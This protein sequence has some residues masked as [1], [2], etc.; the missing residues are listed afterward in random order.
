[1]LQKTGPI[2][3]RRPESIPRLHETLPLIN[4]A[5]LCEQEGSGAVAED[6]AN[7]VQEARVNTSLA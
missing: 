1:M 7:N 3:S 5:D 6:R 4:W 2:M